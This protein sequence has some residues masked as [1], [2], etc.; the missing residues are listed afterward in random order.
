MREEPAIPAF[1]IRPVMVL[2]DADELAEAANGLLLDVVQ[3]RPGRFRATLAHL[4]LNGLSI[5]QGSANLP[6]RVRGR[7]YP[8][9]TAS[10]CTRPVPGQPGTV[11]PLIRPCSW[12]SARVRNSTVTSAMIT[13]GRRSQSPA[14][15]WSRSLRP[16]GT[17]LASTSRL[18]AVRVSRVRP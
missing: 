4:S 16:I 15:G 9:A 13:G 7:L 12:F 5:E 1:R 8:N 10:D 2:D 3:L 6:M 17:L 18:A 11:M 14:N